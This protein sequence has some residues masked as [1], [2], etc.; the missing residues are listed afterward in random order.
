MLN[1]DLV[2]YNYIGTVFQVISSLLYCVHYNWCPDKVFTD[3]RS[4]TDLHIKFNNMAVSDYR[5][6]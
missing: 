5:R 4:D 6:I 3:I 1:T 2:K